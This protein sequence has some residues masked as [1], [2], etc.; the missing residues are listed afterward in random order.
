MEKK[1]FTLDARKMT[2]VKGTHRYLA[3]ALGF[4]D[5]YGGNLDALY[6][7]LSDFG[8]AEII[9]KNADALR[10]NLGCYSRKLQSVFEDAA[11]DGFIQLI[12]S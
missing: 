7:C 12:L 8:N 6:D 10:W 9:I 3:E 5:Y 1:I 4:P 2:T 11:E